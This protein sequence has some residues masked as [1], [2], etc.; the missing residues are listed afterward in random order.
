LYTVVELPGEEAIGHA[1]LYLAKEATFLCRILVGDAHRRSKGIG[2]QIVQE[3]LTIAFDELNRPRVELNVYALNENAIQCYKK[4][5]FDFN[6]KLENTQNS[7]YDHWKS[8]RMVI[9]RETWKMLSA[10]RS[11]VP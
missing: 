11:P 9:D 5:G 6:T 8:I 1:E 7:T 4:A 3:L 10:S 2:L